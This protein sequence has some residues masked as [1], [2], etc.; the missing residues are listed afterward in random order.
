MSHRR[1]LHSGSLK[2]GMALIAS[3]AMLSGCV[4]NKHHA[5]PLVERIP[6]V[7]IDRSPPHKAKD[8]GKRRETQQMFGFLE[9]EDEGLMI[10]AAQRLG[11][12]AVP[13]LIRTMKKSRDRK[14][15]ER[16]AKALTHVGE[17]AVRPLLGIIGDSEDD[18]RH[19]AATAI[20]DIGK[21]AVPVLAEELK[22]GNPRVRAYCIVLLRLIL[23]ESAIF[24]LKE[25]SEK[26]PDQKLRLQA[27]EAID[28]LSNHNPKRPLDY[29]AFSNP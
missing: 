21:P 7:T 6:I 28:V 18:L 2:G 17:P 9:Q 8:D 27:K 24:A 5:Q 4:S 29:D 19:V 3:A 20:L 25:T 12:R 15:R 11:S 1:R 14:E 26:D 16:A 22:D 10:A 23:D 13:P